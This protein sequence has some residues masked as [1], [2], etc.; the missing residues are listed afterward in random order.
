MKGNG[1]REIGKTKSRE[2]TGLKMTAKPGKREGRT[3]KRKK[4]NPTKTETVS[5]VPLTGWENL[6]FKRLGNCSRSLN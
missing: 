6:D 2:N 4:H 1:F 5:S 3:Q